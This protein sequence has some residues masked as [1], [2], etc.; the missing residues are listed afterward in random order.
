ML[1]S[2]YALCCLLPLAF[3]GQGIGQPCIGDGDCDSGFC[4]DSSPGNLLCG[5]VP[6]LD[7]RKCT[8]GD[9]FSECESRVTAL[10]EFDVAGTTATQVPASVLASL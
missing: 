7:A 6:K 10:Y 3:A 9:G 8:P 4:D 1:L 2:L 5:S